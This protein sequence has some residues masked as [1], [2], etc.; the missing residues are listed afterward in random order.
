MSYFC[1]D[2]KIEFGGSS[3]AGSKRGHR[4]LTAASESF[5]RQRWKEG[6]NCI[7]EAIDFA[8]LEEGSIRSSVHQRRPILAPSGASPAWL[9]C[10]TIS[11]WP[12][13]WS[14]LPWA[15]A[16]PLPNATIGNGPLTCVCSLPTSCFH[17]SAHIIPMNNLA[18][19][20]SVK[21]SNLTTL[22]RKA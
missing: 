10:K 22:I 11:N 17:F 7:I 3:R 21:T 12:R 13:G 1:P 15:Q 4:G 18:R 14:P 9:T 2:C 20:H 5:R 19:K 8:Q 16:N 6:N